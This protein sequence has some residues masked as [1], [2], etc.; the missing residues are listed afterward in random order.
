MIERRLPSTEKPEIKLLRGSVTKKKREKE[1][2]IQSPKEANG[3]ILSKEASPTLTKRFPSMWN[4][5]LFAFFIPLNK[6][7]SCGIFL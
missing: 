7:Q 1:R 2:E 5:D 6:Q 3:S 4:R